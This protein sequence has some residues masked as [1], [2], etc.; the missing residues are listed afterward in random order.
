M[1]RVL[2]ELESKNSCKFFFYF[3]NGE[4][5]FS[6]SLHTVCYSLFEWKYLL[7]NTYLGCEKPDLTFLQYSLVV[8]LLL[9]RRVGLFVVIMVII[10]ERFFLNIQILLDNMLCKKI[11]LF[12]ELIPL[13]SVSVYHKE[14]ALRHPHIHHTIIS[15]MSILHFLYVAQFKKSK[16]KKKKNLWSH[17]Y[18]LVSLL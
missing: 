5:F 16:K 17:L 13:L 12:R 8:K 9:Q 1:S 7:P 3:L 10:I 4:H 15:K 18:I 2:S 11:S 6:G 14:N